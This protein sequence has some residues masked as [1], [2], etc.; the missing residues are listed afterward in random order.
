MSER[1]WTAILT[2]NDSHVTAIDIIASLERGKARAEI[3]KNYSGH[4]LIALIP[5]THAGSTYTFCQTPEPIVRDGSARWVDPYDT[6]H[7]TQ[8]KSE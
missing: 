3:E 7:V 8:I 2:S 6:S 4:R 5:G 1:P